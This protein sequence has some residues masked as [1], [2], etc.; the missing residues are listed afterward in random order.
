MNFLVCTLLLCVMIT[1]AT[2]TQDEQLKLANKVLTQ[3]LESLK[4]SS[5][6][7][8]GSVSAFTDCNPFGEI[9]EGYSNCELYFNNFGDYNCNYNLKTHH[10]CANADFD[11]DGE[12]KQ[13]RDL[14]PDRCAE[15]DYVEDSLDEDLLE[16]EEAGEDSL[17]EGLLD[18]EDGESITSDRRRLKKGN[19]V[20]GGYYDKLYRPV[21]AVIYEHKNG[22]GKAWSLKT[23]KSICC[24]TKGFFSSKCRSSCRR[25]KQKKMT[26]AK[27]K[28]SSVSVRAG[29]TLKM[30]THALHGW[31]LGSK[32]EYDRYMKSTG[33]NWKAKHNNDY[34]WYEL[35]CSKH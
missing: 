23:K 19:R 29:C 22:K 34:E 9:S 6:S 27:N 18:L 25:S 14:C 31:G 5:E 33:K 21:G 17:D 12:Y 3:A 24:S 8:V 20:N 11:Y 32:S 1:R 7:G 16:I 13:I 26:K 4:E 28:V 35:T 30:W 15:V 2:L 10:V